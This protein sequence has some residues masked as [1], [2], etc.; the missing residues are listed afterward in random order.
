MSM[1]TQGSKDSV[2]CPAGSGQGL[3]GRGDRQR[4]LWVVEEEKK[5]LSTHLEVGSGSPV[6]LSALPSYLFV[7]GAK[8]NRTLALASLTECR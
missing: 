1:E 5:H 3:S 7:F 2:L 6:G 8:A 4:F